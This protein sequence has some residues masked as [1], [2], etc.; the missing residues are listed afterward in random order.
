MLIYLNT[1][2]L[3]GADMFDVTVC[4]VCGSSVEKSKVKHVKVKGEVKDIC[5]ECVTA[6]TGL[7]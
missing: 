3:D 5:E 4:C 7:I 2:L 1:M 6:I